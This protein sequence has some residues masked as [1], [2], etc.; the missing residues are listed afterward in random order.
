MATWGIQ[1]MGKG[2]KVLYFVGAGASRAVGAFGAVQGG[3]RIPIPTQAEFWSVF[4]RFV[5]DRRARIQIESFLFRYFLGYRR[6]PYRTRPQVRRRLL[7]EVDVEEVF[8]FLSERAKAPSTSIQFRT[9]SQQIWTTLVEQIG[10]VFSHFAP[11]RRTRAI[12]R[13]F[14]DRHVRSFDS[15][16]SFNYDTI[17]EKSLPRRALWAYQGLED[18][19]KRLPILKPHGSINW[20]LLNGAITRGT[21]VQ[22]PIV[23]APSHL[24]FIE[25]AI[26]HQPAAGYLDQATEIRDIWQ[27]MERE[28]REAK[29]LVFIGYSFPIAD[30]YFSSV[31]RTVLADRDGPPDLVLVNPDAVAI[32]QRLQS[33]FA[34]PRIVKYFDFGQFI[35]AGRDG[36]RRAVDALSVV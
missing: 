29:L 16:V 2:R 25:A 5:R 35:E 4:L 7:V 15:V 26:E 33:R 28:M 18:V 31:L 20:Q 21:N 19:T 1:I 32:A 10:V 8:T 23:V 34:I 22:S 24:K 6:T 13:D 17:F 30:L 3:G 11:N 12:V 27:D 14:H 9:Y 36:V